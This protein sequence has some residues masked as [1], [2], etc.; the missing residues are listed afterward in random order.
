VEDL[1]PAVEDGND[2]RTLGNSMLKLRSKTRLYSIQHINDGTA[3]KLPQRGVSQ[4]QRISNKYGS[5]TAL[6]Q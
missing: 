3:R 2:E 4:I 5:V 1:G 6:K